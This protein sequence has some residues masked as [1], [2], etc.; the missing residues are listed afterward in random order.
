V[1][2]HDR[3]VEV[4]KAADQIDDSENAYDDV[5]RAFDD[6]EKWHERRK[7]WI[8]AAAG[9]WVVAVLDAAFLSGSGGG[10]YGAGLPPDKDAGFFASVEP[11]RTRAGFAFRF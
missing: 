4:Y 11:D 3:A 6:L 7:R 2:A 10:S 5:L 1:R 8:Y 9:V